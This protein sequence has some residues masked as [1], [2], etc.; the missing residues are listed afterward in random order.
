MSQVARRTIP[1][2]AQWMG[3]IAGYLVVALAVAVLLLGR[4]GSPTYHAAR[5][6]T[7]PMTL[8]RKDVFV[9]PLVYGTFVL[10]AMTTFVLAAAFLV[11]YFTAPIEKTDDPAD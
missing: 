4:Y 9:S 5:G 11:S 1:P 6:R 10:V 7:Y 8:S 3:R 2:L